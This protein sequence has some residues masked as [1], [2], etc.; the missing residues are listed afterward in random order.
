VLFEPEDGNRTFLGN[1]DG[2]IMHDVTA[3]SA[4]NPAQ[5]VLCCIVTDV[6]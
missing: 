3:V 1:V 5:L 4:S 2:F 6:R